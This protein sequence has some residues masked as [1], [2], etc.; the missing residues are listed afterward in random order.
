MAFLYWWDITPGNTRDLLELAKFEAVQ[1]VKKD[2]QQRCRVPVQALKGF[3]TPERQTTRSQGNWGIKVFREQ[4]DNLAF[5][6]G[7]SGDD[8]LFLPVVWLGKPEH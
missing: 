4:E 5:E 8:W 3:L 7:R 2:T 6:P 1:F